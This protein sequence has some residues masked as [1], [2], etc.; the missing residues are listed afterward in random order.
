MDLLKQIT[1]DIKSYHTFFHSILEKIEQF[2]QEI[3][4]EKRLGLYEAPYYVQD[5]PRSASSDTVDFKAPTEP[6]AAPVQ[7]PNADRSPQRIHLIYDPAQAK[8]INA[9][10]TDTRS[11]PPAEYIEASAQQVEDAMKHIQSFSPETAQKLKS[12][13]INIWI[14]RSQAQPGG[15]NALQS[16]GMGGSNVTKQMS[17]DRLASAQQA[18][19]KMTLA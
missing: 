7:H 5:K 10:K 13:Q 12:G 1:E 17:P 3:S 9:I 16:T 4:S 6:V 19:D 14:P 2:E 15:T 11:R 18:A 8:V